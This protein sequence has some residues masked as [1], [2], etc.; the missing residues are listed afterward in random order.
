MIKHKTQ[1]N[2]HILQ[3][4]TVTVL[5]QTETAKI[6]DERNVSYS[7]NCLSTNHHDVTKALLE[8]VNSR[9]S[10]ANAVPVMAMK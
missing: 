9:T 2:T 10:T 8:A 7:F 6:H 1:L 5:L 4:N 3:S